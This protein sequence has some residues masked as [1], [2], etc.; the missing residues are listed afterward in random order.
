MIYALFLYFTIHPTVTTKP[1]HG[2]NCNTS[3]LVFK[4]TLCIYSLINIYNNHTFVKDICRL[5]VSSFEYS[6]INY[7][8]GEKCYQPQSPLVVQGSAAHAIANNPSATAQIYVMKWKSEAITRPQPTNI[9]NA[10]YWRLQLEIAERFFWQGVQDILL[11]N[12]DMFLLITSENLAGYLLVNLSII[13]YMQLLFCH[14]I[15]CH[16]RL[17]KHFLTIIMI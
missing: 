4:T 6:T 3:L 10:L 12:F 11:P 16:R 13:K 7:L 17:N 1:D 14:F 15:C 8:K 2:V 5:F 9:E